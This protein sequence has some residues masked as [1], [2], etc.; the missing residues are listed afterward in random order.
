MPHAGSKEDT[1]ARIYQ[2][3]KMLAENIPISTIAEEV[4]LTEGGV[5]YWIDREPTVQKKHVVSK[6][7]SITK[8]DAIYMLTNGRSVTEVADA[9]NL[10]VAYI[11]S[12]RRIL[13]TEGKVPPIGHERRVNTTP[14]G[15]R[16]TP[17]KQLIIDR[18]RQGFSTRAIA[19]EAN[20]STQ[21]VRSVIKALESSNVPSVEPPPSNP[22]S[23]KPVVYS[24]TRSTIV[25][26][27][28]NL[29]DRGDSVS[30]IARRF[31][32]SRTTIQRLLRIGTVRR[33]SN[34]K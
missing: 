23:P 33:P 34:S 26:N 10:S 7:H 25:E 29:L 12:I 17:T 19:A 3:K 28:Q 18:A 8:E 4:G 14:K 32:L 11:K 5:S 22:P 9:L 16:D 21:W 20:C 13:E 31:E 24:R 27:I 2:I 15:P 30:S 1:L 6:K